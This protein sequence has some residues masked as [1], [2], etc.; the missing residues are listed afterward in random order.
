MAENNY[1]KYLVR[2]PMYEVGGN[3]KGRQAPT[4]TYMSNE[5]VPGC[6][7][8]IDLS[9]IYALPEPNPHV[10]EHSHNYDKIV[11][12]IGADTENFE[13]LGGEIEYY[14]GGQP[15]A[16]DTTTALYIPKGI[17]HG[18]ITWKKFTKPHIEM[19][20]MLGAEST[21]GGWLSGDISTQK[22]GL[23][24][25]KDDIDY[26]KYLV[27]HPAMLDGT[28]VTEA[29]KSP[30]KIYMSSDLIPESNV[31][32]DFGWIPDFPDPNPPIPDHVHDYE[33]VVLLIGGDPNNPEALGAELEFCVGD[34]PLPFNTT[35]ACYLPKGIQ[36]GPLTWK[37]FDRPH[38]LMPIIIGAGT[39]AQAAP[40]GQKVE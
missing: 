7:L 8:Y 38:L 34:Q 14:V 5:L 10:F 17:K 30:A 40:A 32:I 23:P 1:E 39:F 4:M 9:W 28:D 29:I 33:E 3:V 20:I 35:V 26:E 6:N 16:F 31:Y 19:S 2:R 21:E 25:K 15:L 18:P 12:H 24:V 22:E 11:L 27:R 13:D 37:K 36:H